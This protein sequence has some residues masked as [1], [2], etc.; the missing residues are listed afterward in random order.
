VSMPDRPQRSLR[1]PGGRG[2]AI[3]TGAA[4]FLIAVGAILLFAVTGGSPHWLNVRALGIILI[5]VGIVGL[6][7]PRATG[8]G[9]RGWLGG[10][11]QPGPN[12][13]RSWGRR[14]EREAEIQELAAADV[15]AVE[16]D[17]DGFY[18]PGDPEAGRQADDL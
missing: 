2:R 4:L 6:L 8:R 7:L 12:P 15:A 9:G 1:T 17:P 16:E 13:D 10:W 14:T 3:S 11:V 5:L 18:Q